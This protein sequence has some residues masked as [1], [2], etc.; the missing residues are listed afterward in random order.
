MHSTGKEH[1]HQYYLKHI[2]QQLMDENAAE[3][4]VYQSTFQ[5]APCRQIVSPANGSTTK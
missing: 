3:F 4:G 5:V 1:M 2:Y